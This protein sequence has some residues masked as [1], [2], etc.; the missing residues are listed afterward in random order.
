MNLAAQRAR[1]PAITESETS[2]WARFDGPAG[3]Q[4][5]D[6]VLEAM[7][8]WQRSGNNANLGG[9]FDMAFACDEL[10][11]RTRSTLARFLGADKAG[12]TIG[13]SATSMVMRLAVAAAHE[14][15]EGDEIVCTQ[16]DHEA[17]VS[18]W[19]LV[20]RERGVV[21]RFAQLDPETGTLPTEAVEAQMTDRTKWVAV[22]GASNVIGTIPDLAAITA[23]G[24]AAGAKVIVD[25]VHLTPH[26]RIDIDAIGCD[27]YVTSAYKWYGPHQSAMWV[28]PELLDSLQVYKVRPALDKGPERIEW[29]T[30]PFEGMAGMTAAADYLLD[31]DMDA[32]ATHETAVFTPLLRGLQSM[33]HVTTYGMGGT[34]GRTPTIYFNVAGM[35][36]NEVATALAAKQIAVWSGHN[37]G[38]EA[39]KALGLTDAGGGV[40]AGV[41]LYTSTADVQRLVDAVAELTL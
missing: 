21:V 3:T 34:E 12:L 22:T 39:V 16:I 14:L 26:R 7:D 24:Q 31:L 19:L 15:G 8:A 11:D 18:P 9:V 40:R 41:S 23:V 2:E 5:V 4:V 27:A 35:S 6:S 36:P 32:L 20:A 33:D 1:F 25:G 13:P 10:A 30:A 29:G 38:M 17:N 37:Y 28:E